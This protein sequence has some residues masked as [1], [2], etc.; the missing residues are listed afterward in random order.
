MDI[1]VKIGEIGFGVLFLISAIFNAS[2]TLRHGKEFYDNFATKA[3][4]GPYRTLIRSIIIPHATLFTV[5]LIILLLTLALMILTR[6]SLVQPAL[7]AGAAFGLAVVPASN[8]PGATANFLI[9]V[10]LTLLAI[11]H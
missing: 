7:I 10:T 5:L 11:A 6:G 1:L 9:A 4:F 3:W 2:Y 8:I